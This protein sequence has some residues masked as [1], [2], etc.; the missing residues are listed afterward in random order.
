MKQIKDSTIINDAMISFEARAFVAS[1]DDVLE[2]FD[3]T[4]TSLARYLSVIKDKDK[5]SAAV[6]VNDLKGNFLMA[7]I[8]KYFPGT[9]K[10]MPGNWTMEMTFDVDDV[11][12]I[13]VVV[14]SSIIAFQDMVSHICWELHNSRVKSGSALLD[15]ITVP[16]KTL[17]AWLDKNVTEGVRTE[18]ELPG[19]F[20][21]ISAIEDG[22]IVKS[23]VPDG[24]ITRIVKDDAGIAQID[25]AV[26]EF[27]DIAKNAG[28]K[29]A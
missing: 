11:K 7:A 27:S 1:A 18:I 8:A 10:D 6:R 21:A 16:I 22:R 14:D 9:E 2:A 15:I 25:E 28:K 19:Y 12:N 26:I 29:V 5:G 24:Q 20:V 4:I 13:A 23:I 3:I 17:V